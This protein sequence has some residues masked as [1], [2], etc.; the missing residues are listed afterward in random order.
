MGK[1]LDVPCIVT[2]LWHSKGNAHGKDGIGSISCGMM[3]SCSQL[4]HRQQHVLAMADLVKLSNS[5][6][7]RVVDSYQM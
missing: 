2:Y 5:K 4:Q 3:C 6:L 1:I 7:A